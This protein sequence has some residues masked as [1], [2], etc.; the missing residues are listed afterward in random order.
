MMSDILTTNKPMNTQ[1][2]GWHTGETQELFA[3]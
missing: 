3:E 2:H 1:N